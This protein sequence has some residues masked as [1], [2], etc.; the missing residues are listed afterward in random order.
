[1]GTTTAAIIVVRGGAAEVEAGQAYIFDLDNY[2]C[3]S[4]DEKVESLSEL[5]QYMEDN[6]MFDDDVERDSV[7][8]ALDG[9]TDLL[10]N[11]M[12]N[13]REEN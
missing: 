3:G 10:L 8:V 2:K 13:R 11:L 5:L 1:M 9:V 12:G 7:H 6:N 4:V